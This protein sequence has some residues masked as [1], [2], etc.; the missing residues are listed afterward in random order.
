MVASESTLL[1]VVSLDPVVVDDPGILMVQLG[2]VLI[3]VMV[4]EVLPGWHDL[5]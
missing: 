1:A 5:R 4:E 3:I 2:V